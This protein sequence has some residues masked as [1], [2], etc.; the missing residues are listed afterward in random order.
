MH[1]GYHHNL[2]KPYAQFELPKLIS[3]MKNTILFK[4]RCSV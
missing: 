4:S 2:V 3:K 1:F